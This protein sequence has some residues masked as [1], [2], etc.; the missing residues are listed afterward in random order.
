MRKC[1]ATALDVLGVR[2]G[3]DLLNVLL[4]PMKEKSW[5]LE[6]LQR[7]LESAILALGAMAESELVFLSHF[8]HC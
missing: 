5:S 3:A 4:E 2:F 6:W 7:E 8:H 1:A